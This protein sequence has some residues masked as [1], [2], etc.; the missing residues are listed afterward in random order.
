MIHTNNGELNQL[1]ATFNRIWGTGGKASLTLKTEDGKVTAQL[2]I[3][4][5]SP[6]DPRPG[7]QPE[8]G[9]VAAG[10]QPL[11]QP[12]VRQRRRRHRG[13]GRQARD[14]ARREAWRA[15]QREHPSTHQGPPPP[16]PPTA[17]TRRLITVVRNRSSEARFSQLDGPDGLETDQE[18]ETAGRAAVQ[19]CSVSSGTF[20]CCKGLPQSDCCWE[21]CSCNIGIDQRDFQKKLH[22][23]KL[24][25][26]KY[27]VYPSP[28]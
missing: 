21:L 28:D 22:R 12:L 25:S 20:C 7:A 11:V 4:L 15:R 1:Y 19:K 24:L 27:P 10:A 3:Q 26:E 8:A 6:T 5:G 14:V 13:P 18:P 17:P 23:Q 9:L 2:E 16:P